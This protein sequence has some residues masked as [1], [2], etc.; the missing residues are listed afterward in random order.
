MN[1]WILWY[2]YGHIPFHF[3][4]PFIVFRFRRDRIEF[5]LLELANSID[6]DHLLAPVTFDPARCSLTTH[7]LHSWEAAVFYILLCFIPRVRALG[8]GAL[9]H[10]L[11][12]APNC[13]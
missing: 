4:L 11:V 13:L 10:L 5:T 6:F 12:D 8:Y 3:I 9:L 1:N 2:G 7:P